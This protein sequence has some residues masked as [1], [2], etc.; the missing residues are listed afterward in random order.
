MIFYDLDK[1]VRG[2][3]VLLK[4]RAGNSYRY[5]VSEVFITDPMAVWVRGR[6]MLTLRTCAPYPPS[7]SV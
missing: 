5:S 1:L 4:D 6:D 7:R 3:E 2:E